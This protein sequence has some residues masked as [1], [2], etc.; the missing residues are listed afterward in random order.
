[1]PASFAQLVD[2]WQ[3]ARSGQ[4]VEGHFEL[5]ALPGISGKLASTEGAVSFTADCASDAAGRPL[6]RLQ[7]ATEVRLTCQ[8]T[9]EPFTQP[10][11]SESFV[12]VVRDEAE[13][14]Q[15]DAAHE[16]YLLAQ[17]R[18]A[19]R[20]LVTEELLLALPLVPINPQAPALPTAAAEESAAAAEE[21]RQQP[22]AGLGELLRRQE[23]DDSSS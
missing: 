6:I 18:L 10:L 19:W 13:A 22:F 12:V 20:D 21:P 14:E 5:A 15:V 7:L 4:R 9:L 16:P 17:E 8:R 1:M 2:P 3:A 23:N 11:A